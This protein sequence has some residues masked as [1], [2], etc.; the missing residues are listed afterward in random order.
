MH[1]L[2]RTAR[3]WPGLLPTAIVSLASFALALPA[4]AQPRSPHDV[5]SYG[6]VWRV[7]EMDRVV[8]SAGIAFG[9]GDRTLDLYLPPARPSAGPTGAAPR[10]P[11]PV[12]VFA[13]VTGLPFQTW[14]IY[15]DWG[16]LVAAHGMAGVVYQ[17]DRADPRKSLDAVISFLSA[18]GPSLGLDPSR[19]AIWACSANVTLALPWLMGSPPS[20][21][22]AAVL[23]YGSTSVPTLRKDLPV[24]YVLAGRDFPAL[25]EGIRGHFTRAAREGVPWTMVHAPAL[26]HA[27]D[28]LDEGVESRRLVKETV[29][30]LV[31]RLVSPPAEGPAP[32]PARLALT[33]VFGQEFDAAAEAYRE[34]VAANP[35]DTEAARGLA[36]SLA[37][38]G[39][40][41]EAIPELRRAISM[42]AD[43]PAIRIALGQ[44]L[45]AGGETA[46]GVAEL[47]QAVTKG[48]S[49]SQAYVQAGMPALLRHDTA[50][51]VSAWEAVLPVIEDAAARRTVL[52]NLACAHSLG[53]EK[54]RALARLGEAVDAGFG[55]RAAIEG[56][57]DLASLRG[58]PRFAAILSRVKPSP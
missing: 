49:P 47:K 12:V 5:T 25:N 57:E 4:S 6:V 50:A 39:R 35:K 45:L 2:A 23:Y 29:A 16:R 27:F 22:R 31:D 53:G 3:G 54:D 28:A 51:A 40:A 21:V 56:D 9:D 1:A 48:A 20:S 32:S 13:N 19:T 7:P 34:I 44:A 11:V 10:P 30:W 24:F 43:D 42:G 37:R 36:T 41:K 8:A 33:H 15:R 17:S 26:T 55:P 52:Y 46:A 58:D 38:A 18:R 14:E